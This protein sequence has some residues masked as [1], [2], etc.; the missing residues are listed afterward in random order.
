MSIL[1]AITDPTVS[2]A[3]SL[4]L[5]TSPSIAFKLEYTSVS[6]VPDL[7][8]ATKQNLGSRAKRDADFQRIRIKLT[9]KIV[10]S[11]LY[12]IYYYYPTIIRISTISCALAK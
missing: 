1:R 3:A 2:A 10:N 11:N 12:P 6:C 4:R 8:I 5:P 7:T 9:S